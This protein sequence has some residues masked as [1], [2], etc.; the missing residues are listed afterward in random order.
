VFLSKKIPLVAIDI[1]SSSIKLIKL[2]ELKKGKHELT[3]FG[4]MPLAEGCVVEGVV[5]NPEMVAEALK[6]LI[7]AEKSQGNY[8]ASS[9]AGEAV[10]IKKI[11]VPLMSKDELFF[12]VNQEA[13]QY[14]PFDINDVVLD[15][16]LLGSKSDGVK[17][18]SKGSGEKGEMMEALL[19]AVQKDIINE[20]T[21]ILLD[22]GLKPAIIDLDLFALMN[23]AQLTKDFS[24][25]GNTALIDLG[26]SF[27]HINIIQ[28]G[29]VSYSRD[30]PV[31]GRCL[32][33]MLL[34]KFKVPFEQVIEIKQGKF[35]PDTNE[36]EVI[37]TI[38]QA[39]KKVLDE[40][41]KYFE[42]IS[43]V[44]NH[45]IKSVLLCGGGSMIRGLDGFFTDY[46]KL[47]VEILNPMQGIKVNHKDFDQHLVHEM[48][49]LSTV[50]LGLA[51]RRFD[52]K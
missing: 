30:I 46:L 51:R 14:I 8:A 12:K 19:V 39:Y 47:P 22:A 11:K 25:M 38:V 42:Y 5:K 48:S 50:A 1:G 43:T 33:N 6:K 35:S 41:Q 29:A 24:S 52:Y 15:F 9:V 20:R 37:E 40:V 26:D 36:N 3:H 4:V 27:T 49:G 32:T 28:D 21:N 18:G 2:T 34:S 45:Q 23:A 16:Q 17:E 13:E 7:K 44:S 10:F 31:G